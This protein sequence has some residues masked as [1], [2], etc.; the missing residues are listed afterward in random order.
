MGNKN[1]EF[2]VGET[3]DYIPTEHAVHCGDFPG[4]VQIIEDR[5]DR[6]MCKILEGIDNYSQ[7]KSGVVIDVQKG[8]IFAEGLYIAK[9][10]VVESGLTFDDV[11]DGVA[12]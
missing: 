2:I 10:C 9:S 12:V 5:K 11:F 6:V 4:R 3:Y 7:G 1:M 8:S